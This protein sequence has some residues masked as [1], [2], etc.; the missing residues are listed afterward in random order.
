MRLFLSCGHDEH[1]PLALRLKFDLERRNHEVWSTKP[2]SPPAPTGN[3]TSKKAS[4]G[5]PPPRQIPHA[6]D[7][8]LGPPLP[9]L[10]PQRTPPAPAPVNYPS[11]F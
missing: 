2:A 7:P 8:A 10:L 1:T 5:S 3:A 6:A 11:F 9:R 4:I